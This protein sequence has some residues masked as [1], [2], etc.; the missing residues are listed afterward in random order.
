MI[1]KRNSTS[2]S[3]L[4][5]ILTLTHLQKLS[6]S[7]LNDYKHCEVSDVMFHLVVERSLRKLRSRCTLKD[8][9]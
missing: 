2:S 1:M 3:G 6:I 8:S 4:T 7:I 5:I 9:P